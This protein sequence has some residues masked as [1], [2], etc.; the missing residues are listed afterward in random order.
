MNG[1]Y[2]AT[3]RIPLSAS[4][5]RVRVNG[6]ETDFADV[7]EPLDFMNVACQGRA[8]EG[9]EVELVLGG[10][11]ATDSDWFI[12]GQTPGLRVA[13]AEAMRARRPANTVPIQFGDTAISLTRFRPGG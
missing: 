5:L 9:A 2:R 1:A 10:D 8:C 6:L 11:G 12:I 4:P 3:I 7:G 13:A